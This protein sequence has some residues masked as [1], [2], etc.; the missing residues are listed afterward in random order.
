MLEFPAGCPSSRPRTPIWSKTHGTS[1]WQYLRSPPERYPQ[2]LS[3]I[4]LMKTSG[5]TG[6]FSTAW[7][8]PSSISSSGTTPGSPPRTIVGM[9]WTLR[10]VS[11]I[12]VSSASETK[13]SITIQSGLRLLAWTSATKDSP[14]GIPWPRC[15]V[16]P[17]EDRRHDEYPSARSPRQT[18][19]SCALP[20]LSWAYGNGCRAA[21]F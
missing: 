2:A 15:H 10:S 1:R 18:D 11:K 13:R 3:S 17:I 21:A 9:G 7:S 16:I 14:L 12:A 4:V 8:C 19:P 6:F 5:E 20:S